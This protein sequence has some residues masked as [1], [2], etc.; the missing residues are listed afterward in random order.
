M[1]AKRRAPCGGTR[2]P[3]RHAGERGAFPSR[4]EGYRQLY[5]YE[6]RELH[7]VPRRRSLYWLPHWHVSAATKK[8]FAPHQD[9]NRSRA[10]SKSKPG[11]VRW[12]IGHLAHLAQHRLVRS[13][14]LADE[15]P[16]RLMLGRDAL[17]A[18]SVAIYR[19]TNC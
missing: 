4:R 14:S 1:S 3:E 2:G 17:R 10:N 18:V 9:G 19:A 16:Q 13:P 5:I 7:V 15:M 6:R 8:R 12:L 11:L